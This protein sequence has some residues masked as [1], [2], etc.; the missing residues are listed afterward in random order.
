MY[1]KK[2]FTQEELDFHVAQH[3]LWLS[4]GHEK[5][6]TFTKNNINFE[7]LDFSK[8]K[9]LIGAN[10]VKCSFC[11]L[12]LSNIN[13]ESINFSDSLFFGTNFSCAILRRAD[14]KYCEIDENTNFTGANIDE[15][16]VDNITCIALQDLVDISLLDIYNKNSYDIV[17]EYHDEQQK[18]ILT[19]LGRAFSDFA[20]KKYADE[21]VETTFIDKGDK[22]ICTIDAKNEKTKSDIIQDRKILGL[23]LT[24]Q[25]RIEELTDSPA[26]QLFLMNKLDRVV[27]EYRS[28]LRQIGMQDRELAEKHNQ[29]ITI[30]RAF[31]NTLDENDYLKAQY[32]Q[33]TEE[34]QNLLLEVSKPTITLRISGKDAEKV[35][36]E[37]IALVRK[38]QIDECSQTKGVN[39]HVYLKTRTEPIDVIQTI[40]DL[41]KELTKH[42]GFLQCHK[43]FIIK[44]AEITKTPEAQG[45]NTIVTITHF[46][47]SHNIIVSPKHRDEFR[48]M[49]LK[50][51]K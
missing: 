17:L 13:F 12:D 41:S 45:N 38:Y 27:V 23:V 40:P 1:Q 25:A 50:F 2:K 33:F 43:E 29:I 39:A 31:S 24:K 32:K 47:T 44:V 7:G 9:K 6:K 28:C 8:V 16:I 21:N 46:E 18:V 14:F 35:N 26:L 3:G 22:V 20:Q 10:L 34:K 4:S 51:K 49:Y 19:E 5:G 48:E 15:M 36:I 11:N 37:D 42:L 30:N